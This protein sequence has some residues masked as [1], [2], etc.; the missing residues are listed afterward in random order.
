MAGLSQDFR[1]QAENTISQY[2]NALKDVVQRNPTDAKTI[3]QVDDL[4]TF[5]YG[6]FV[7]NT[8]GVIT[9]HFQQEYEREPNA[10]E[11]KEVWGLINKRA[12]EVR[13]ILEP[14]KDL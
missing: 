7:G 13:S 14:L 10:D 1:T 9:C 3:W 5:A 12:I 2:V 8:S 4:F 6:Q 11:L